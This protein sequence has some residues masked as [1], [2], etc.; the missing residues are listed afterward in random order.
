MAKILAILTKLAAFFTKKDNLLRT[1]IIILI[2]GLGSTVYLQHNKIKRITLEHRNEIKLKNALNDSV[3]YY[4]NEL[5]E[6][7]AE[8]LTLQS[9]IKNLESLNDQLTASEKELLARLKQ[10]KNEKAVI[11][12]ALVDAKIIIDS[13]MGAG[14]VA[15]T[16]STIEFNSFDTEE[17][18]KYNIVVNGAKPITSL[19]KPAIFFNRLEFPNQQFI[20]FNWGEK[21]EGYPIEFSISNS[22]PYYKVL[23]VSSYAIPELQKDVVNPSGW[24]KVGQWFKRNGRTIVYVGAGAAIG[25]GG[26]YILMK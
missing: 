4:I 18:F 19:I 1:I 20:K 24:E 10:E 25:A 16:D 14:D 17:Y 11:V 15:V 6:V 23:D 2:L 12:A 22:N 9:T 7:V 13:L 8:K 5:G 3:N 26:T 21:E